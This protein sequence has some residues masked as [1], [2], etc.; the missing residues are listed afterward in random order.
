MPFQPTRYPVWEGNATEA[1]P[2]HQRRGTA[3][4]TPAKKL[5]PAAITQPTRARQAGP[6]APTINRT[7]PTHNT[8]STADD[9]TLDI[10]NPP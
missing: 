9:R 1:A 6:T 4:N 5:D 3:D 2:T 7:A 10:P 8:A